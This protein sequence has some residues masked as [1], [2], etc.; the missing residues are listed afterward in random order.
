MLDTHVTDILE[1]KSLSF[2]N[3]H[4]DI[5][6]SSWGPNDDG[7]TVEG[8]GPLAKQA[9]RDGVMQGRGGRGSIFIFAAGNGGRM[10][11]SC[12]CDGYVSSVYSIG[13]SSVTERGTVPF[14]TEACPSILASTLSSGAFKDGMI[15]ST[16]IHGGCTDKMSGTSASAPLAAGIVALTLQA[17]P[18]L[19]WRDVDHIIVRTAKSEN[20][21]G[22]DWTQ[23]GAGRMVSHSYG[24]GLMDGGAMAKMAEN[25]TNVPPMHTCEEA[26]PQTNINIARRGHKMVQHNT[27]AC[28]GTEQQVNYLEH[29]QVKIT[30][31]TSQRGQLE[32]HLISPHG[33]RST[34]L[35]R[36]PRDRSTEGFNDWEFMSTHFWGETAQGTWTLHI[37]NGK[38]QTKLINWSLV[39]HGTETEPPQ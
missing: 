6:T 18:D 39:L 35:A 34:L 38:S 23:N 26:S 14:Y 21:T 2:N 1:A 37:V 30:L 17:N 33:T 15:V 8:P 4:V 13:I 9:L 36:R 31:A 3:Q 19:T 20:L 32:I 16:D 28:S 25:W 24:Y 27:Q 12:S 7:R 29:V 11:D 22:T 10:K 5:Y